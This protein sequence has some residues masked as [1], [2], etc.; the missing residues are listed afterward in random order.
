MGCYPRKVVVVLNQ[1]S[2]FERWKKKSVS[3]GHRWIVESVISSIKKRMFG[4]HVSARKYPNMIRE[5]LLKA[6][7]YNI[8]TTIY[9]EDKT[10]IH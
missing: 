1:L 7:L 5:I 6:S 4:E 9:N 8:F 3:Y 10:I 2:D